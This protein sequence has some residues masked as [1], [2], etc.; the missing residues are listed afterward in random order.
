MTSP[1]AARRSIETRPIQARPPTMIWASAVPDKPSSDGICS[2]PQPGGQAGLPQSPSQ[3]PQVDSHLTD[4]YVSWYYWATYIFG[5]A[6]S[7]VKLCQLCVKPVLS[8]QAPVFGLIDVRWHG[9]I[10]HLFRRSFV[11]VVSA[12]I[13]PIEMT[14]HKDTENRYRTSLCRLSLCG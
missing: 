1:R 13:G 5:S 14:H 12:R 3:P 8:C 11:L 9:C 7:G 2:L 6:L 10:N 4:S